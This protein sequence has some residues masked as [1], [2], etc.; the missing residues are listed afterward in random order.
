[1][2]RTK[3][4]KK[5]VDRATLLG[6]PYRS[7]KVEIGQKLSCEIRG[8]V[9]VDDW[10]RGHIPWPL[11]KLN[12]GGKGAYIICGDLAKAIKTESM[13]AVCHWWGAGSTTVSLWRRALGVKQFNEG[14][15]ALWSQW[16]PV[17]LPHGSADEP[18]VAFSPKKLRARRL[19]LGLTL[20]EVAERMGWTSNNTY[21]QLEAG[22]REDCAGH[23]QAI[24]T[25]TG[26]QRRGRCVAVPAD[27]RSWHGRADIRIAGQFRGTAFGPLG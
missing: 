20:R 17:K 23:G 22:R 13:S 5:K 18:V 9:K 11:A 16:R 19:K 8:T 7:P 21:Q 14:T 27:L 26:R 3:S 10:S 15:M 1:M 24:V 6:G 4:Q 25:G 2:H 12:N